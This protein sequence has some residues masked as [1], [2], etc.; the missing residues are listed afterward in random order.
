MVYVFDLYLMNYAT[1]VTRPI[2]YD[3]AEFDS[4][5]TDDELYDAISEKYFFLKDADP[6]KTY[7]FNTGEVCLGL[8]FEYSNGQYRLIAN[9]VRR[10]GKQK[11]NI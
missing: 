9:N 11:N 6:H 7:V 8:N 5:P 3:F 2:G 1:N 4:F 10:L